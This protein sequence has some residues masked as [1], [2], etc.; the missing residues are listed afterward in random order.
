MQ[1]LNALGGEGNGANGSIT[2]SVGQLFFN[3]KSTSNTIVNHGVQ[4]VYE[5]T[6]LAKRDIISVMAYP[7]P[8][9]DYLIISIEQIKTRNLEFQF[10]DMQGKLLVKDKIINEETR[11]TPPLLKNGFFIL[12]NS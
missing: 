4:Q 10:L 5:L 2:Y 3:T 8:M 11:I 1:S 6:G 12:S 7:N 9:V